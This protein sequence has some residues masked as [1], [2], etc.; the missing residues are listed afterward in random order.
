VQAFFAA[1]GPCWLLHPLSVIQTQQAKTQLIAHDKEVYDIGFASANVFAS[2][3]ADGSVR[4]FDLRSLDHSTITY[5]TPD[6]PLLRLAWNK[7]DTN[8]LA[9]I[10][11]DSSRAYLMV[12]F[13]R[14]HYWKL[15]KRCPF[16]PCY[17]HHHSWHS[18]SIA[19]CCRAFWPFGLCQCYRLG[20]AFVVS[21]LYRWWWRSGSHMGLAYSSKTSGRA[22][23]GLQCGSRSESIAMVKFTARLGG[24]ILWQQASAP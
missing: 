3:G 1:S 13:L 11:M 23:T 7:Q 16:I 15:T 22:H 18:F 2:V 20:S 24:C 4:L 19:S 5:E 6:T 12:D 14:R 10:A 8:Y 21:H 17:R 9:T